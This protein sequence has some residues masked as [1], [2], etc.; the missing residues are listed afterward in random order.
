MWSGNVH[1]LLRCLQRLCS[2]SADWFIFVSWLNHRFPLCFKRKRLKQR[3]L[4]TSS[5]TF[6]F[7][8]VTLPAVWLIQ[9]NLICLL[10]VKGCRCFQ[11]IKTG[12]AAAVYHLTAVWLRLSAD[13]TEW[14]KRK[15]SLSILNK[16]S[17]LFVLYLCICCAFKTTRMSEIFSL[18]CFFF[19][20]CEISELRH[21]PPVTRTV[22][23]VTHLY[24]FSVSVLALAR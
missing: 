17:V 7:L 1:V 23:N 9:F 14:V 10:Q 4:H 8:L 16:S 22:Q 19:F 3:F 11:A 6:V 18:L 5:V 20:K 21:F 13:S 2:L 15:A 24:C 12:S